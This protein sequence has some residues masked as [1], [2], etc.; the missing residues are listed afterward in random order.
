MHKKAS[1]PIRVAT[2]LLALVGIQMSGCA[3]TQYQVA[4][5]DYGDVYAESQN[6][7]MLLN[8]ARMSQHHP[9]YFFQSGNIQA[10]YTFS[11]SFSGSLA[12]QG[13]NPSPY[14]FLVSGLS[15]SGTRTSQPTFNFVPL[16]GGDFAAHLV[17]PL[18]PQ[19][20]HAFFHAGFP[21]DILMRSMVQRVEFGT[22]TNGAISLNN[23][24]A[25][26]NA[27]NYARFLRLC[28]MLRDLQER[29]Y[30]LLM[31]REGPTNSPAVWKPIIGAQI[32]S[33]PGAKDITDGISQGYH[34]VRASAGEGGSSSNIWQLEREATN[35]LEF[36]LTPE[37]VDYL[38]GRIAAKQLPYLDPQQVRTLL[39]ILRPEAPA[40]ARVELRSFQFV[41]QNMAAEQEE[42]DALFEKSAACM[43]DEV[44]FRQ[45]RP[46][47]RMNWNGE[48]LPLGPS[49]VTLTYQNQI[50]EIRDPV[51]PR[52]SECDNSKLSTY[53]SYNRDAFALACALFSQ[54]SLDPAKLN[55]QQEYL[56]TR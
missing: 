21:V 49:L 34:W 55:F 56:L 3:P 19:L 37:G 28:D 10:N 31:P 45:R 51:A 26:E 23:V 30:L 7:Q 29:G 2:I 14:A 18:S 20:F 42:F 33:P 40:L 52:C 24:P 1:H 47:I 5:K 4:F 36:Q 25:P 12:Q 54:I 35:G 39:E 11:G 38:N 48:P 6:R 41:L 50:F 44:P 13:V 53:H 22:G 43:A 27:T 16:V 32:T 17:T 9:T 15:A 8:L 46:V